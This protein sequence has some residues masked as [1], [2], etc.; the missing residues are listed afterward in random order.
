MQLVSILILTMMLIIIFVEPKSIYLRIDFTQRTDNSFLKIHLYIL[1][2]PRNRF[3]KLRAV[4]ETFFQKCF[5]KSRKYV[6]FCC[7]SK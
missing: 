2:I 5:F 6:V 4:K 1:Q 7:S 3:R